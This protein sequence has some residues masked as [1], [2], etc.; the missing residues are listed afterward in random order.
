MGD[1]PWPCEGTDDH[2]DEWEMLDFSHHL[3]ED[4]ED[5]RPEQVEQLVNTAMKQ[6]RVAEHEVKKQ[7]SQAFLD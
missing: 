6:H 3:R 1:A 4:L 7:T 5:L 2:E